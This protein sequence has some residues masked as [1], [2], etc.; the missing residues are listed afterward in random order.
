MILFDGTGREAAGRVSRR[1]RGAVEIAAEGTIDAP[2]G[3][4]GLTIYV[5]A[6]RPERLS[7]MAEKA[8]E[9]EVERFVLIRTER[10]QGFRAAAAVRDR[11]ERVARAAAK[12]SSAARLP[13]ISGPE[14][15][16]DVVAAERA[17][18]RFFL[19]PEGDPFPGRLVPVPSAIAV[20]PEGGWTRG[21]LDAGRQHGWRVVALPAGRLRA[22]TA[23]IAA[24]V[25]LRAAGASG[26]TVASRFSTLV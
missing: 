17:P 11:L 7:W 15:V 20:G 3:K 1:L 12:Q 4:A 19:D 10:T 26:P 23:M 21:E 25:L 13:E 2:A 6:V 16:A 5:A 18:Q 8:T 22:E 24:I 9:L 14:A